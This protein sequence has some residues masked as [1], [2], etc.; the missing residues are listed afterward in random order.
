MDTTKVYIKYHG[1]ETEMAL[2][3]VTL[4]QTNKISLKS[5]NIFDIDLNLVPDSFSIKL[6]RCRKSIIVKFLHLG[7]P[8]VTTSNM[9]DLVKSNNIKVELIEIHPV[10]EDKIISMQI[11]YTK[12]RVLADNI[13]DEYERYCYYSDNYLVYNYNKEGIDKYYGCKEIYGLT[14]VLSEIKD[15]IP[16]LDKTLDYF[17]QE[18]RDLR[19]LDL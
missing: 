16:L 4:S 17:L 10:K 2:L 6:D 12:V 5:S 13:C 3:Y 9:L 18:I 15:A 7:G 11:F 19:T 1:S 14:K 8:D